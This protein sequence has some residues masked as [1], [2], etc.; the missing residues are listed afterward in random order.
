MLLIETEIWGKQLSLE[1]DSSNVADP[2]IFQY[3]AHFEASWKCQIC[4]FITVKSIKEKVKHPECKYCSPRNLI[5]HAAWDQILSIEWDYSK[6]DKLPQEYF[7]GSGLKV[8]WVCSKCDYGFKASIKNRVTRFGACSSCAGKVFRP[9]V[10]DVETKA[11]HLSKYWD[12]VKNIEPMNN[13]WFTHRTECWWLCEKGHSFNRNPAWLSKRFHCPE[14]ATIPRNAVLIP[15][16]NDVAT[17]YP[18]LVSTFSRN[19]EFDSRTAIAS[20]NV[21]Y[22]WV[23]DLGHEYLRSLRSHSSGAKCPYCTGLKLLPGFNDFATRYPELL[24]EWDYERN[25]FKPDSISGGGSVRVWWKCIQGHSWETVVSNRT[26]NGAGCPSCVFHNSKHEVKILEV[27]QGLT[28]SKILHS[29]WSVIPKYEL[30]FYIP[31]L[32]LAI[33]YNG[34]YWHSNKVIESS[35]GMSARDYHLLKQSLCND[36]GIK[37][38]FVW[39]NDWKFQRKEV[40]KD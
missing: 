11:S 23:C 16:V 26:K 8:Y 18:E 1:W 4:S 38:A 29:C 32:G 25:T 9:G 30:D 15:G 3:Q 39:D 24:P 12:Y 35:R 28:E 22:L 37:L 10:N 33:E 36:A 19:N 14:C 7:S 34:E 5:K 6:N 17:L 21:K 2:S 13:T 40:L 31:E 20:P 27:L